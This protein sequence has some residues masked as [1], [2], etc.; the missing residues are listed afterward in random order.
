MF[1]VFKKYKYNSAWLG[2]ALGLLMPSLSFYIY[3]LIHFNGMHF[4]K[5]LWVLQRGQM[6]FP[7]FTLCLLPDLA[8]FFIF[9]W[10]DKDK[11]SRGFLYVILPY[12]IYMVWLF[13]R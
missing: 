11:T 9:I 3:Y 10:I 4:H 2:L 5:L 7:L 6:E 13:S 8:G 1:E 12:V